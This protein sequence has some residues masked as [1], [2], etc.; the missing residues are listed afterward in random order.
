MTP[1]G[2]L[3]PKFAQNRGFSLKIARKLHV[4]K[5][6]LWARGGGPPGPPGSATATLHY[7]LEATEHLC[8]DVELFWEQIA[9]GMAG[10]GV[11]IR[12]VPSKALDTF[13]RWL[14][15]QP[16]KLSRRTAGVRG[17]RWLVLNPNRFKSK[18]EFV[19][20]FSKRYLSLCCV[21]FHT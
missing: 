17:Y 11:L 10:P 1:W 12:P 19:E 2:G 13:N 8:D 5:K 4:L 3:S 9:H 15:L 20:L 7:G 18:L 14:D 21:I 6:I 16:T